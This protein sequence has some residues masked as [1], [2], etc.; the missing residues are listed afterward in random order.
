[1]QIKWCQQKAF[2]VCHLFQESDFDYQRYQIYQSP[3]ILIKRGVSN[4]QQ[5]KVQFICFQLESEVDDQCLTKQVFP[6]WHLC[7]CQIWS[8]VFYRLV[9]DILELS[10]RFQRLVTSSQG[11]KQFKLGRSLASYQ[12]RSLFINYYQTCLQLIQ[13]PTF[14]VLSQELNLCSNKFQARQIQ[15]FGDVFLSY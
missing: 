4:L 10:Y 8:A 6:F 1:M 14:L 7:Q 13:V 2:F 9:A 11:Q 12:R 15:S 3:F 5:F